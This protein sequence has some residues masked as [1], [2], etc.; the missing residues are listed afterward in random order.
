MGTRALG[1]P[2]FEL[3]LNAT[4]QNTL[5]DNTVAAAAIAASISDQLTSGVS[6]SQANRGWQWKEFTISSG[7]NQ[8]IDLYDF[9]G[10]DIGG[11]A[12]NDAVGQAMS[13]IEEI[14]AI[15][16]RNNNAITAA[17]QL[18]VEPDSSNGWT[19]IGTHTVA[20]GG[21][22]RGQGSMSKYQPAES[23]FD[24]TDASSHR[25]K[26]TANGGDVSASVW[27]LGRHDDDESSSSSSSQSSQS[28]SSSSSSS[29]SSSSSVSSASTSSV[30]SLSSSSWSSPSSSS[31]ESTS[32]VSTSSVST[33]SS[34]SSPSSVSSSSWSSLS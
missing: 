23:A 32:S 12:G 7:G 21:A 13:P 30:S 33:S 5:D 26:L 10:I 16:V 18:E 4:V 31:S 28:S 14:V 15:I 17:G 11:G 9:A 24:V 22:L 29:P 2:K 27:I 1:T 3:R 20:T 25:L 34:S 8:V 6:A 19:P